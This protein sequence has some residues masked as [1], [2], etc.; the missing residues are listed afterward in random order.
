MNIRLFTPRRLRRLL[1]YVAASALCASFLAAACGYVADANT[2][3]PAM[4]KAAVRDADVQAFVFE[5][6]QDINRFWTL[7][8]PDYRPPRQ[9]RPYVEPIKTPCGPTVPENA[10][11]CPTDNSIYYDLRFFRTMYDDIGRYALRY[12]LAHEWGHHVQALV[13]VRATGT[14]GWTIHK[15]LQ[16][17]CLAG[18][19]A[20]WA[21]T[22]GQPEGTGDSP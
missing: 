12:V 14:G 2:A 1:T 17:D 7:R 18:M 13:G 3:R 9:I 11:Y 20:E 16:A 22:R 21:D 15:E 4:S 5:A 8:M 6:A 10:L 19:F